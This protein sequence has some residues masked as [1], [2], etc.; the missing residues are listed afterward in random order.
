M[1]FHGG[2]GADE[3]ET[4]EVHLS[5]I[6]KVHHVVKEIDVFVQLARTISLA[7]KLHGEFYWQ[8]A[9]A[10]GSAGELGRGVHGKAEISAL[11]VDRRQIHALGDCIVIA[12]QCIVIFGE[13]HD[14]IL[15]RIQIIKGAD[16]GENELF[17]EIKDNPARQAVQLAFA[18][19]IERGFTLIGIGF[20]LEHESAFRDRKITIDNMSGLGCGGGESQCNGG[21]EGPAPEFSKILC[22]A[23]H[24]LTSLADETV[25]TDPVRYT[26]TKAGFT[27]VTMR[28][29]A[30]FFWTAGHPP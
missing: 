23:V 12:T 9:D 15:I 19:V 27:S 4:L 8:F 18:H 26:L 20:A 22:C 6:G 13:A 21:S 24:L 11:D 25:R 10:I 1:I 2:A 3:V 30:G 17:T 5:A 7:V 14:R 16:V 28:L 29:K